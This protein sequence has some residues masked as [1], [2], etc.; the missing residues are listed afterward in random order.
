MTEHHHRLGV[1]EVNLVVRHMKLVPCEKSSLE[2]AEEELDQL[3]GMDDISFDETS[4]VLNL[5]YDASRLC[6]D[7][8]E[9]VLQ[10]HGIK[11]SHDWWTRFK[12]GYYRFIDQNVKDHATH[13]PWSCHKSPPGS[14]RK[15]R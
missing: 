15:R 6:L 5:A 7:G 11:V 1:S 4:N 9:E 2:A 12:E 14:G 13:K 10:K 8:I 3:Y